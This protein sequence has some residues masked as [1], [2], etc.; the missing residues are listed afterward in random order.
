MLSQVLVFAAEADEATMVDLHNLL[1]DKGKLCPG[2]N[3][4]AEL[5][6]KSES[7][8]SRNRSVYVVE[9]S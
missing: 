8:R 3:G 1:N 4:Q 6:S 5:L 7:M 9:I 2:L